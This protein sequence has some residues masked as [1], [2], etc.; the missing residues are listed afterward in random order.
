[1]KK[2]EWLKLSS[3]RTQPYTI[4]DVSIIIPSTAKIFDKRLK[5]FW[6]Q[7]IANSEAETIRNTIIPCDEEELDY[8][9]DV[10]QGRAKLV[11]TSPK[12]I[13]NKTLSALDQITTRLTFRLANDIMI[14]RKGWEKILIDQFNASEK[15][16]IIG[17]IQNGT[18]FPESLEKLQRDWEYL[19]REYPR[20][21]TAAVYPHGSRIFAQTAVWNGY[22]RNVLRYTSHNHD[23]IYFSQLARG[24]GIQFTSFGGINLYLNHVGISNKDFTDEYIQGHIAERR[25]DLQAAPDQHAFAIVE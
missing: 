13:V 14:I 20:A 8:L 19:K 22:Y 5:W 6:P 9:K 10:T 18:T 24:D 11:P 2:H 21:T 16:Q 4:D 23:E 7:Y 25:R 15:L 1:M 12:W 17:E 3:K